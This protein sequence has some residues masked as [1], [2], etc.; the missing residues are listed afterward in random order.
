[1]AVKAI[2]YSYWRRIKDG[3]RTYDSVPPSV[4]EDVKTLAKL[5]V[6]NGVI[7]AERFEELIGEPYESEIEET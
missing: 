7:T 2:A 1:M 4:A 6:E 5:D 3:A